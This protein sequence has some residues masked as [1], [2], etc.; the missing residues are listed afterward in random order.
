MADRVIQAPR[1]SHAE[2]G[3]MGGLA[4]TVKLSPEARSARAA[5]GGNATLRLYGIDHYA[6]IAKA[7][8]MRI[9]RRADFNQDN[10]WGQRKNKQNGEQ[11][12]GAPA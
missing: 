1:I 6:M 2:R 10:W 5:L 7:S 3:R 9:K 4:A 8:G 12:A 11:S